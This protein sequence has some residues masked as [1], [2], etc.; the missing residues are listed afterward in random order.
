M[1]NKNVVPPIFSN[2]VSYKFW[3]SCIQ[4]CEAV[5]GTLKNEQGIIVLSI[6]VNIL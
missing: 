2:D 3:K 1:A 5:C 6:I 4:M